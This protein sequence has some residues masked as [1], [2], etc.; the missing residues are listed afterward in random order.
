MAAIYSRSGLLT[1][2]PG[3]A[4]FIGHFG[5]GFAGKRAAPAASLGTLFLAAQFADL[6]WPNLVLLGIERVQ[7]VPGV[8][9]V[10]PLAFEH[11]PY[12]HSLL[13][14]VAWGT[15]FGWFYWLARRSRTGAITVG[16][17]VV[18]HWVLD[19]ITHRQDMPLTLAGAQRVGLGLWNSVAA[20][21]VVELALFAGG[22]WFYLRATRPRD[23]TGSFAL[24]ALVVFLLIVYVASLFGPP[25]PSATAVAWS[26]QAMWLLVAWGF[27]IDQHREAAGDF[28]AAAASRVGSQP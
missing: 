19:V 9:A 12:S 25:P 26:A 1:N 2:K 15:L 23:R 3:G 24:W 27:W 11:Y 20:T 16:V 17:L 13:A 18:S 8:T 22:L 4:V 7:V 21:L 5:V 14:L 6:L 28:G 10:T